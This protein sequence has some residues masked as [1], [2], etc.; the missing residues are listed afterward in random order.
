MFANG[1]SLSNGAHVQIKFK[2]IKKNK[3]KFEEKKNY[4]KK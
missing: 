3:I 4:K 2:F 1:I